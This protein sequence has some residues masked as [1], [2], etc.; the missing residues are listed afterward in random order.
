MTRRRFVLSILVVASVCS[1]SLLVCYVSVDKN[2]AQSMLCAN[3]VV[4]IC[5]SGR[6]WAEEQDAQFP[7]NFTCMSNILVTTKMLHCPADNA[8]KRAEDW[9][10]FTPAHSSYEMVTPGVAVGATNTAFIRCSI[11]GHIG[12]PDMTVFDGVRRRGKFN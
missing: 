12:Y 1:A 3:Q 8:H 2:K 10:Q 7:T 6:I 4:S 5:Y 9:A 11:H